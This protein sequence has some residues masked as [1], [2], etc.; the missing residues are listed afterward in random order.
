MAAKKKRTKAISNYNAAKRKTSAQTRVKLSQAAKRRQRHRGRFAAQGG[1]DKRKYGHAKPRLQ[2]EHPTDRREFGV[3][4]SANQQL[5]R[6]HVQ[7]YKRQGAS[8]S[9]ANEAA[10]FTTGFQT[11]RMPDREQPAP[12]KISQMGI[13]RAPRSVAGGATTGSG[14]ERVSYRKMKLAE[15][16]Q[17]WREP[18]A[19]YSEPATRKNYIPVSTFMNKEMGATHRTEVERLL[20]KPD[21]EFTKGLDTAV[22]GRTKYPPAVRNRLRAYT[23]RLQEGYSHEEAL[24]NLP[25]SGNQGRRTTTYK[26]RSAVTRETGRRKPA[27]RG[28]KSKYQSVTPRQSDLQF[29]ITAP[30]LDSK[31]EL[32]KRM[33][34]MSDIDIVQIQQRQRESIYDDFQKNQAWTHEAR[35]SNILGKRGTSEGPD[36]ITVFTTNLGH[37]NV[38]VPSDSLVGQYVI[39]KRKKL[40]QAQGV[41]RSQLRGRFPEAVR[42][43]HV[44]EMLTGRSF[45]AQGSVGVFK[46]GGWRAGTKASRGFGQYQPTGSQIIY[47]GNGRPMYDDQGNIRFTYGSTRPFQLG[48]RSEVGLG[49][50]I[51]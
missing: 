11:G 34:D 15:R 7:R 8:D 29:G 36:E 22:E 1:E 45:G 4:D 13:P 24:K 47:G 25:Q 2:K 49:V 27:E 19:Y 39:R 23:E 37:P 38:T 50:Y 5:Y 16:E 35:Q 46:R 10:A 12:V 6:E 3:P 42:D 28:R 14:P 44:A 43:R 32:S 51:G 30:A 17:N 33:P 48:T 40:A 26:T 31:A 18:G 20:S 21:S 9:V 41:P